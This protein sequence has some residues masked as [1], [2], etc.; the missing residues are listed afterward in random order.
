MSGDATS[1]RGVLESSGTRFS[2]L[3][4]LQRRHSGGK[5][6]GETDAA[7]QRDRN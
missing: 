6:A 4:K 1:G 2:Y 7:Q 5:D 3:A